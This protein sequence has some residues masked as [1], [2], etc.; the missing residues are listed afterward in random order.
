MNIEQESLDSGFVVGSGGA[1]AASKPIVAVG[2]ANKAYKGVRVRAATANTV[3]IYVGPQ[4]VSV[5]TGYPL[6][7]GEELA[8]PIEDPSKINVVATPAANSQQTVT[9]AGQIAGDTFTLTLNGATTAPIAVNTNA[10]AVQAALQLL[11]TV[12]NGNCS[13]ADTG[14]APPYTVTFTGALAKVDVNLMTATGT[15][16]NEKQNVAVSDAL[17]GDK[18]MLTFGANSTPELAYDSTSAEIQTALRA[19]ASI[20]AGN[21]DVTDGATGWDV[22]FVGAKAKTDVGAISGVA[23][24]NEKQTITVTGGAAGDKMV[25][26]YSGQP[27]SELNYNDTKENVAAAL[28]ALN[29]IGDSDVV[30]TNGDPAG[31]VVEFTGALAKTDVSAITGVCGK[32]EKQTIVVTG[33]AA[34]DKMVLTYSGQPTSEL[35]YNDTKENIAAA[36]KGLNNIGDNDVIVTDGDPSGWVVEFTGALAKTDVPAIAGVCGKNEKQTIVVTGGVA[37][38]K[39]VLTYDGQ[40]TGE[41]AYDA[42]SAEVAAALK[43]LSNI[44]DSDVTVTD[45][46]PAGWVV[47]FTGT[48][49]KTDVPAITG[50]CGKNEKQTIGLDDGVSDGTFTLTYVDQTTDPIAYNASALDVATA[51]KALSNIG[52]NDVEV[53]GGPGP[54]ADWVVE[55]KGALA[56]TD[57]AALVGDGANLTGDTKTVTVTETVKGNHA[58]VGVTETVKG[59]TATVSVTETVKGRAATVNVTETAKGNTATVTV[60]ETQKGDTSC[61]VTMA[62]VGDIT[63][64]SKYSWIAV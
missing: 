12:G 52:D 14:G 37:N 60:T 59:N 32:N 55:F 18:V 43:L 35:N 29:N 27:T 47:E 33:G 34:G 58:T 15:G 45:G 8:I 50:V 36:L 40:P 9:L 38:D 2:Y 4:G 54:T 31:W 28:K 63:T 21:V 48:L 11:S 26:T 16:V 56:H 17:A 53:T 3:V 41:L 61:V 42:T 30:V 39:L 1:D 23:G 10:A 49:A 5:S 13:V 64:G 19:L 46:D 44:G 24:K 7:A 62:K 22:E 51:L 25:L 20:G 6:P 57:I